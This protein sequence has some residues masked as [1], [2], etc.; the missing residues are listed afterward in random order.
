M[1]MYDHASTNANVTIA[2]LYVEIDNLQDQ[3]KTLRSLLNNANDDVDDKLRKLNRA[4]TTSVD[5]AVQLED[6]QQKIQ[7]LEKDLQKAKRGSGATISSERIVKELQDVKEQ[8]MLER[9]D[10]L[11]ELDGIKQVSTNSR[12]S[13]PHILRISRSRPW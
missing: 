10:L 8:L 2:P 3:I 7:D 11:R 5:L 1:S 9:A 12:A 13:G 6:A 4:G